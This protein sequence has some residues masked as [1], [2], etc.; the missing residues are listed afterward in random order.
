[1]NLGERLTKLRR[2]KGLSQEQLAEEL[3]LTRQTISK[4]ELNQS[5]PDI[6]YLVKISNY[7]GVTTDYL[8]KG[9]QPKDSSEPFAAPSALCDTEYA[10]APKNNGTL[11]KWC[12][13][14]GGIIMGVSLM[15]MIAF[16]I[17]SAFNPYVAIVGNRAYNGLL[18]LLLATKTLWAF[19]A[20]LV[21]FLMGGGAA[22]Y[23]IIKTITKK[24]EYH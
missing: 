18:G 1:M 5:T 21:L 14:L 15:G 2:S 12:V 16:F 23:G 19:I 7:F 3:Y 4:W 8:I 10:E 11:Y 17:C 20:L 13:Y 6:D 24:K 22:A 9:E